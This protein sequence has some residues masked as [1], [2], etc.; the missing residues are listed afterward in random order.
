MTNAIE[1]QAV[2]VTD[3]KAVQDVTG[4]QDAGGGEAHPAAVTA[5]DLPGDT[6]VGDIVPE[7]PLAE[8]RPRRRREPMPANGIAE[9]VEG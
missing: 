2:A 8:G 6:E 5:V 1:E 3:G 4:M 9:V 7:Q